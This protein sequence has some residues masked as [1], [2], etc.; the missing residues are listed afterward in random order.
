[1][2][3]APPVKAPVAVRSGVPLGV[4]QPVRATAEV[5]INKANRF[6]FILSVPGFLPNASSDI[7]AGDTSCFS[8]GRAIDPAVRSS[9]IPAENQGDRQPSGQWLSTQV[10]NHFPN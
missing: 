1:M 9:G 8:L 4:S 2:P 6:A 10:I 3:I 5:P 7:A